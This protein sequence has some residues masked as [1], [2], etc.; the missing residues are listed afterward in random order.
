MSTR[1]SNRNT[2]PA[3][4]RSALISFAR[5]TGAI[6][7]TVGFGIFAS[8]GTFTDMP[9]P[10]ILHAALIWPAVVGY[11][12]ATVTGVLAAKALGAVLALI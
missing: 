7:L 1:N 2:S 10:D 4:T 12:V 5:W 6:Y 3:S 11:F 8:L 9:I